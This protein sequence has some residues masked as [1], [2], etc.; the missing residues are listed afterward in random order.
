MSNSNYAPSGTPGNLINSGATRLIPA[1]GSDD[2]KLLNQQID[3][4]ARCSAYVGAATATLNGQDA[5]NEKQTFLLR[6]MNSTF[7]TTAIAQ[8]Y[9]SGASASPAYWACGVIDYKAALAAMQAATF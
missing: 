4:A 9:F 7:M 6:I 8:S 3:Y 1:S 2:S 5:T